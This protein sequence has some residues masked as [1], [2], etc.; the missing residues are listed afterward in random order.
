MVNLGHLQ[1]GNF[2]NWEDAK[3]GPV[4]RL[5]KTHAGRSVWVDLTEQE[6]YLLQ[7]F[8]GTYVCGL[9]ASRPVS[10]GDALDAEAYQSTGA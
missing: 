9:E 10:D 1:V 2:V 8:L 4:L 6:V 5:Q 7:S 3:G